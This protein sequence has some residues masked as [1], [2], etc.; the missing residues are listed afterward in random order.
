MNDLLSVLPEERCA[1]F[2]Y[3]MASLQIRKTR[4]TSQR[5]QT[6]QACALGD[7]S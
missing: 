4:K 2:C 1:T 7:E 6:E 3:A 5:R